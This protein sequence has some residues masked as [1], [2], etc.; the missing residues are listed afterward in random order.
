MHATPPD[1]KVVNTIGAGDSAVA[2]F[3]YA[4]HMGF[5]DEEALKYAVATGT[6]TTLK[7]GTALATLE[8]AVAIKEQVRLRY[9]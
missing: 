4:K 7:S 3:I 2:S 8:D 6:A 9:L 5:S 1:V